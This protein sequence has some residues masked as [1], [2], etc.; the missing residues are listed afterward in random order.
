MISPHSNVPD[1]SLVTIPAYSNPGIN[2]V[3]SFPQTSFAAKYEPKMEKIS[4]KV[5]PTALASIVTRCALSS[6][7]SLFVISVISFSLS[8]SRVLENLTFLGPIQ[9]FGC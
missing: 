4:A 8:L 5:S 2:V 7:A 3:F 9:A 1:K 6:L